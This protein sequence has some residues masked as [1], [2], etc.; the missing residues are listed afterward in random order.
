VSGV[1]KAIIV[2]NLCRDPEIK[3]TQ[4]SVPVANFT[5]ATS[6]KWKD[7]TSGEMQEKTEYHRIV[8]WRNQAEFAERF[9]KKGSKVYVEGRIE[10]RKWQG[11]D[12][13]DRYTTEIVANEVQG[14]DRR[15]DAPPAAGPDTGDDLPF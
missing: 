8:A 3:Y 5:V 14:L 11:Q 4:S 1:N 15:G 12:G 9:L 2:G 7:K 10:T 6:E 13:R